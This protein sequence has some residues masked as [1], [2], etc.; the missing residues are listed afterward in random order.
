[1]LAFMACSPGKH[2]K[3]NEFIL[4]KQKIKGNKKITDEDLSAILRQQPNRKLLG[5]MPGVSIY[6]FGKNFYDS[7]KVSE[8]IRKTKEEYKYKIESERDSIKA[9]KLKT[10]Y[11]KR[12]NK[13]NIKLRE[14]NWIMR[15]PG[16]KPVIYDSSITNETVRQ[17]KYY[18]HSKGFF[19]ND[20]TAKTDTSGKKIKLKYIIKEGDPFTIDKVMYEINDPKI[21]GIISGNLTQSLIKVNER[22]DEEKVSGERE[23]ISKLLKDNGYFEFNRQ[24]ILFDIDTTESPQKASIYVIVNNPEGGKKHEQYTI[25]KIIFNTD[26]GNY[27]NKK[28]DTAEFNGVT[29]VY[30]NKRFSKKILDYKLQFNKGELYNQ[31]KVNESQIQFASLDMFKFININF[32]KDKSDSTN[33]LIATI[34]TSPFNKFQIS[35]EW[36][37]NVGQ[38]FIPGPY[39]SLTFKDRNV[40][41]GF[42]IFEVSLRYSLEAVLPQ[43]PAKEDKPI[44]MKEYGGSTS[45]TFPQIFFPFLGKKAHNYTPKTRIIS[46]YNFVNRPEYIRANFRT[47]LNY[48]WQRAL[49]KQYNIALIDINIIN[50][51]FL[52][53]VF[54]SVLTQIP[55]LRFSFSNSIVTSLNASYTFN[56]NILGVVK[57][58]KYFRP[59]IEIGGNAAN[60]I[61]QIEEGSSNN[62]IFELQYFQFLKTSLDLRFYFPVSKQNTFAIRYFAGFATPYGSSA[63]DSIFALPYEKYFFSG[64][65]SSIRAWKPRRLGPGSFRDPNNPYLFEQPGEII[66][67]TNYEYRFNIIKFFD[68]AFFVDA[69]NIWTI[70]NEPNRPGSNFTFNKFI[71]TIAVGTGFG[72]RLDFTFLIL[73][74]DAG[75]KVWDPAET[76]DR[77][78][79]K[80]IWKL[81]PFGRSGQTVFN[82]GIGYPF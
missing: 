45:L 65:S 81:P 57:N 42:E 16:A 28:R 71:E 11:E 22:Y 47:A 69:G 35:D 12:I 63:T 60:L 55:A 8:E 36:G 46:G 37:L 74:L 3:E 50:T 20:I 40:F 77:F 76:E 53:P 62:K 44:I 32:E 21:K 9:S 48:S 5:T 58:S 19:H 39:A 23:R 61:N 54:D 1:M 43:N 4:Y 64:G 29:Y 18:I 17:I 49:N 27:S 34:R 30:F 56:N 6:Y 51:P 38:G 66:F 15:A 72:L 14:G 73:R 33:S 70:R 78:V 25:K 52:N 2:L 59:F 13:L 75:I 24:Y 26:I 80:Y 68:G 79:G 82:I 67:E 10:K 7:V 31:K 41:G